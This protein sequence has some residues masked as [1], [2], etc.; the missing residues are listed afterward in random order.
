[1]HQKN[2]IHLSIRSYLIDLLNHWTDK[3]LLFREYSKIKFPLDGLKLICF[4]VWTKRS[5]HKFFNLPKPPLPPMQAEVNYQS[6]ELWCRSI[7]FKIFLF[8]APK[9]YGKGHG[10]QGFVIFSIVFFVRFCTFFC[11]SW[12]YCSC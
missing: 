2:D 8:E 7:S 10:W 3:V 6:K 5:W 1:M 9:G 12:Q 4:G 11:A